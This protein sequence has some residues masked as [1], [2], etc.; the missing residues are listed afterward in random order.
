[1]SPLAEPPREAMSIA[2]IKIHKNKNVDLLKS[3]KLRDFI[4]L[5]ITF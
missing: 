4:K 5:I 1:M 2:N 3:G